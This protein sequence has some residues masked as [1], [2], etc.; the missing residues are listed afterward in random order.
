MFVDFDGTITDVDTF[1]ALVRAAVGND[2]WDAVDA[3]LAAGRMTLRDGLALQASYIR[4]TKAE[5]LAFLE[6]TAIVDP[7]FSSFVDA[8]R[9]GGAD[10]RVVSSGVRSIIESTLARAGVDVS[11][12]A[13]DVDFGADGW[14]MHFIDESTNGHDKAARVRAARTAG[15]QTVYIGD[16]ISD[17][18]AAHEADRCFAKANSSLER[19]CRSQGIAVTPFTSFGELT[20]AMFPSTHH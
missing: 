3:E 11:I 8:A 1:D 13:N 4:K 6:A 16:G 18:A 9:S 12:F 7:A 10:V 17:F 20:A 2:V 14:T 19:Y 5:A 15:A